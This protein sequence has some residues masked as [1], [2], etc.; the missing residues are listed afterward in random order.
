MGNSQSE[1]PE[2][3]EQPAIIIRV[4]ASKDFVTPGLKSDEI[5]PLVCE[6]IWYEE[7]L[8]FKSYNSNM[9]HFGPLEPD[10]DHGKQVFDSI[11]DFSAISKY[12]NGRNY[13][14]EPENTPRKREALAF[15]SVRKWWDIILIVNG[16]ETEKKTLINPDMFKQ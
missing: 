7:N 12:K 11:Q 16:K 14:Y 8:P 5:N 4:I 3:P 15:Y 6:L 10:Y 13:Y 1:Q 2:Q 9:V